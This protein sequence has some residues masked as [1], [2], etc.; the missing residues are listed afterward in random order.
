MMYQAI[1]RHSADHQL[2]IV[3]SKFQYAHVPWQNWDSYFIHMNLA[4]AVYVD[5]L[6]P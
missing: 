5:A 4:L 2:D 6:A 1:L 3:Q